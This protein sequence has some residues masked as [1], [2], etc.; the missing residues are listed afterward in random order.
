MMRPSSR[1]FTAQVFV[2]WSRTTTANAKPAKR[3]NL[4]FTAMR[5]QTAGA[6]GNELG[7]PWQRLEA[8]FGNWLA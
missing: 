5:S 8:F 7:C 3:A 6:F 4:G 2:N 1:A